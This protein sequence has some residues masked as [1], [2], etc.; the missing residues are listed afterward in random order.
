MGKIF[1]MLKVG[2][3]DTLPTHLVLIIRAA[4]AYHF[5]PVK[6]ARVIFFVGHG[7]HAGHMRDSPLLVG[8]CCWRKLDED[9]LDHIFHVCPYNNNSIL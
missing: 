1:A 9:V 8:A 7:S 4:A 3:G 5:H 2:A 6:I